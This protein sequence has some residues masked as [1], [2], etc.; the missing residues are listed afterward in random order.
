VNGKLTVAMAKGRLAEQTIA[1][2]DRASFDMRELAEDSRKL[3]IENDDMRILLVKPVDVPVYVEHGVADAGVCGKDTLLES[4]CDLYE[5]LDLGFGACKLSLAGK[6]GTPAHQNGMKVAT[7]YVQFARRYYRERGES[8][9]IIPLSGSVELGP[10]TGLSDIILDIVESGRTL[11]E[12]G[13]VVLEDIC[14]ISA[15]LCVNRVSLKTKAV[16]MRVMI[17]KLQN[18]LGAW[19]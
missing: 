13:L 11:V 1:L 12:N 10:I 16:P 7:K 17:E 18:A 8:V 2:L 6:P 15:R 14:R 4:D 5:M 3:V 9:E 19:Q